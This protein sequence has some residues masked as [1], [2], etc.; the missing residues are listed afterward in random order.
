[1]GIDERK[2]CYWAS[3]CPGGL[4]LLLLCIL[5]PL[6][7]HNVEYYEV[8]FF[9]RRSTGT[10]DRGWVYEAGRHNLG[11]DGSFVKFPVS[12]QT[13]AFRS[14][15]VW[16]KTERLTETNAGAA[17]TAINLDVTFQYRLR[18]EELSDLYSAVALQYE[19]FI[20]NLATTA[21]KNVSTSFT[22]LQ[23]VE[24]RRTIQDALQAGVDN[25]LE[26]A[27]ADC[28]SLQLRAIQ[29]PQTFVDRMLAAAV[30]IQTNQAEESKQQSAVI[31]AK[32]E[33][34]VKKIEN[35]AQVVADTAEARA[36][37]VKIE[38]RQRV[39]AEN[40]IAEGY[41]QE[42]ALIR[43]R[44]NKEVADIDN[45]A[46]LVSRYAEAEATRITSLAENEATQLVDSAR[47]EGIRAIAEALNVSSQ[48]EKVSLDYIFRL[49]ESNS[50]ET[51]LGLPAD[52]RTVATAA[53]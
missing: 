21:I 27:H 3:V 33:L 6:S 42:A 24:S 9:K 13:V 50:V 25:A 32:T 40:N 45:Q 5:L 19:P 46:T 14:M 49:V 37:L 7:F 41:K 4:L 18:P 8:A 34:G 51:Y 31:R 2:S 23:W 30:Q 11:P 43:S 48:R 52:L 20:R 36:N 15:N 17:G 39:Q 10:I 1:M 44:T 16:T 38:A 29:F 47:S 53:P 35:D 12:Q 28:D 26:A 22:A